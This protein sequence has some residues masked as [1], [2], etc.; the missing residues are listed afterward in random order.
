M[1]SKPLAVVPG[2][3]QEGKP[4]LQGVF[5]GFAYMRG[6]GAADGK[7]RSTWKGSRRMGW[8]AL[9]VAVAQRMAESGPKSSCR[10]PSSKRK[11]SLRGSREF[12]GGWRDWPGRRNTWVPPVPKAAPLRLLRRKSGSHHLPSKHLLWLLPV[13]P[14]AGRPGSGLL[15]SPPQLSRI[16]LWP[17]AVRGRYHLRPEWESELLE[18]GLQV[19]WLLG[20][21]RARAAPQAAGVGHW[22]PQLMSARSKA[23]ATWAGRAI[24]RPPGCCSSALRPEAVRGLGVVSGDHSCLFLERFPWRRA[25]GNCSLFLE[26]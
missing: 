11:R 8:D 9:R 19:Y 5:C 17:A 26:M 23:A 4:S 6:R 16:W 3:C 22:R 15:P 25:S 14:S 10:H 24:A 7:Y 12:L 1:C 20:G 18:L 13:L 2:V 21:E